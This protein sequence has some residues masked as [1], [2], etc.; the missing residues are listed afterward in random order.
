[1]TAAAATNTAAAPLPAQ[2]KSSAAH[3]SAP[4]SRSIQSCASRHS[5]AVRAAIRRRCRP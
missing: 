3:N 1:M 2:A 5:V 4:V